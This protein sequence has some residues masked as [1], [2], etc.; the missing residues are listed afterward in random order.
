M[1]IFQLQG[2]SINFSNPSAAQ[3]SLDFE[4]PI[5]DYG[6]HILAPGLIDT[7]VHMDEPGREHW[8]GVAHCL[9]SL[10]ANTYGRSERLHSGKFKQ[11]NMYPLTVLQSE[12]GHNSS[13]IC[14]CECATV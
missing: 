2:L 9:L 13:L 14:F 1:K 11:P 6:M 3:S 4:G 10:N 8:E 7:H 12:I 5:L